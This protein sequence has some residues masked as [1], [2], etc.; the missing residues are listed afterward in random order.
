MSRASS[1]IYWAETE[2]GGS[3][4]RL[5]IT[6][7]ATYHDPCVLA[8]FF[9]DIDSPRFIL[10][11]ILDNELKEMAANK[12]QANCCGAGGMLAVHRPDVSEQI[13]ALRIEEAR[14][15]GASLLVSGCPRCDDTF[16]KT[17]TARGIKDIKAVNLVELLAQAVGC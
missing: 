14:E 4:Q 2:L 5:E 3:Y 10:S 12:K 17:M 6:D 15:T 8:R 1:P 11:K 16:S 9:E 7:D 13:A